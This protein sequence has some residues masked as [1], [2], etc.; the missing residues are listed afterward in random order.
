MVRAGTYGKRRRRQ[1]YQCHPPN[2]DPIHR[3]TPPIPRDHVHRAGATCEICEE[4]RG[5]HHGQTAVARRHA[6]P[7]PTVSAGLDKISV[8]APYGEVSKWALQSVGVSLYKPRRKSPVKRRPPSALVIGGPVK[9]KHRPSL[10][11]R[12]SRNAWHIAADWTEAFAPVV[13]AP[14]EAEL[15]ASALA[16]RARLDAEPADGLRLDRP[17][18][19][20]LDDVPVYGRDDDSGVARR[21][22][23]F[24]LLV[25]AEIVWHDP[26]PGDPPGIPVTEHRIRLVRAMAKSNAAAWR[27]VFDE[28][29]Y[30]PDFVVADAGT[31]IL[32]AVAAHFGDRTR[33]VPS[34][35]H[36]ARAIRLGLIK[37]PGA[38]TSLPQGKRFDRV[39]YHHLAEFSRDGAAMTSPQG[40]TRW[41]DDL[42]A[43]LAGLGLPRDH[44]NRRRKHYEAQMLKVLPALL[45]NPAV[46]MSTGGLE[47]QIQ[48]HLYP[49]LRG[50]RAQLANIER[51]NA[52]FDLV[53]ARIHGAFVHLGQVTELLRKDATG[54]EGWTVA[55][56][57]VA[58]PYPPTGRYSSLRDPTLL[59]SVARARGLA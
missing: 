16:E 23:G 44:S 38:L 59:V 20:L 30:T 56:R 47:K 55:L 15:R 21:D 49:V 25:A 29:A 51:T 54:H 45:A 57:S 31:S 50:R 10:G 48:A 9:K 41:W 2:G 13:F 3:F 35:W 40:W 6:W 7:T 8:G 1:R 37:T 46:P 22:A 18:V 39:L 11:A 14:L 34:L 17:Q 32:S 28:L 27:L 36:V 12:L 52:L 53:V 58:D 33:F 19:L 26:G 43:I 24:Y 42:D 5:T 4:R